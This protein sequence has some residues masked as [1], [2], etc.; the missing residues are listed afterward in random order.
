MKKWNNIDLIALLAIAGSLLP[1]L[2]SRGYYALI[3][4]IL[5]STF[6]IVFILLTVRNSSK[7]ISLKPATF[8]FWYIY[9]IVGF[10]VSFINGNIESSRFVNKM[11]V[12]IISFFFAIQAGWLYLKAT[13]DPNKYLKIIYIATFFHA[14]IFHFTSYTYA[15]IHWIF[16]AGE[17]LAYSLYSRI[18]F[19]LA[20]L[21]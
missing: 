13:D 15:G 8:K 11:I 17:N 20:V 5:P 1:A 16:P 9:L 6:L 21:L 19:N 10:L 18:Q 2:L 14:F 3:S 12:T 7:N 4:S